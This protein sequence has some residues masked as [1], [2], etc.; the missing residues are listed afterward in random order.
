MKKVISQL[1]SMSLIASLAIPGFSMA[2]SD[3]V[4]PEIMAVVQHRVDSTIS[5][6]QDQLDMMS[7]E[8]AAEFEAVLR[9][10]YNEVYLAETLQ[11]CRPQS[12]D[13]SPLS[14]E[15]DPDNYDFPN[16]GV[17]RFQSY[18]YG[19]NKQY[20]YVVTL[21][22]RQ[23]TLDYIL[24]T[25]GK[26]VTVENIIMDILGFVPAFGTLLSLSSTV[27]DYALGDIDDAGGYT[28]IENIQCLSNPDE[29]PVS[30]VGGWYGHTGYTVI[31]TATNIEVTYFPP[32]EES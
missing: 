29:I 15:Y 7:E 14:V 9:E 8:D 31:S 28:M 4:D 18:K 24:A 27:D 20:D 16:G 6:L 5:A 30:H 19:T 17:I 1:V 12:P 22:E 11:A 25:H 32:Y 26:K 2:Q 10:Y 23:R 21:L 3:D 13:I